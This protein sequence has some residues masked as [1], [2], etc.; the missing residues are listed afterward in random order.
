LAAP[1]WGA[2]GVVDKLRRSPSTKTGAIALAFVLA[3]FLGASVDALSSG[4]LR[5]IPTQTVWLYLP[6]VV[7]VTI[8]WGLLRGMVVGLASILFVWWF[9]VAPLGPAISDPMA[10]ILLTI[11]SAGMLATALTVSNLNSR[12]LA[13]E[14]R[15]RAEA[16]SLADIADRL[17]SAGEAGEVL[18]QVVEFT[19]DLLAV[20]SA[21]IATNE[22]DCARLWYT[23]VDGICSADNASLPLD[24]SIAG[25]VIQK[26]RPYRTSDLL[27]TRLTFLHASPGSTPTRALCVPIVSAT[28]RVLG[29]LQ[30]FDRHDGQD[31]SDDNQRLTEGVAHH[32]AVALD[33]V[34]LQDQL[35]QQAY[36]DALTGL[37]NRARF[38]DRLA[39]ALNVRS[40]RKQGVA[41]L[42]VDLDGFKVV[43]DSLGHP[44]GDALL[45]AVGERLAA[46]QR[47]GN[48]VARF[49]GDEFAILL[50]DVSDPEEA[51]SVAGRVLTE[52]SRPF[53]LAWH[54]GVFLTAS[55]GIALHDG[56]GPLVSA[57]D[58]LREADVALY[59]AKEAGKSRAVVFSDTMG[60]RARERLELQT[61]LQHAVAAGELRLD[62]QPVVEM[63]TGLVI[64]AEALLRWDHPR[65]G[66]LEPHA[67]IPIAEETGLVLPIGLWALERACRQAAKWRPSDCVPHERQSEPAPARTG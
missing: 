57:E 4:Q 12:R 22:G 16:E 1:P 6:L 29:S 35:R 58:L 53:S 42:F 31:F 34:R 61:D 43:N 64:G 13:A 25:W 55:I 5:H 36:S 14:R 11:A 20:D 62:Y 24:G 23:M 10:I 60:Q 39:V 27:D 67:F 51:H 50:E 40:G 66:L 33:R 26:G 18:R 46:I 65:R 32:A 19:A 7:F 49:G 9:I 47:A 44:A 41:V 48:T 3:G 2:A 45:K 56:V 38:L 59:Q 28:G 37:P 15:G 52:L 21:G 63:R 8:R 30:L 54:R 17:D